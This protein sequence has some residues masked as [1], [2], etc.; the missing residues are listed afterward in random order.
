MSKLPLFRLWC[1][2]GKKLHI[3]SNETFLFFTSWVYKTN[4][5]VRKI[6]SWSTCFV[7]WR[8]RFN[9]WHS[10]VTK[11]YWGWP[12]E[13]W[14]GSS[15][16]LPPGVIPKIMINH[17]T[18][19]KILK[20]LNLRNTAWIFEFQDINLAL[21]FSIIFLYFSIMNAYRVFCL[22]TFPSCKNH[23]CY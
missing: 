5:R 16:W 18:Y 17:V 10:I 21:Y 9:P 7:F 2:P 11:N 3:R 14:S 4:F 15:S 6:V 22:I 1:V 20:Y 8:P 12:S 13:Q 23:T 19:W